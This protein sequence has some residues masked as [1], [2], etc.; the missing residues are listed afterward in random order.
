MIAL[1][2]T[3]I[4]IWE[5]LALTFSTHSRVWVTIPDQTVFTNFGIY[6]YIFRLC[7]P[8]D[9]THFDCNFAVFVGNSSGVPPMGDYTPSEWCFS[10]FCCLKPQDL[11]WGEWSHGGFDSCISV[12]IRFRTLY[13]GLVFHIEFL[14]SSDDGS[15]QDWIFGERFACEQTIWPRHDL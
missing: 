15:F 5:A 4:I 7:K 11:R 13:Q 8:H 10:L 14:A 2:I 12:A 3:C 6:F 1:L 9:L